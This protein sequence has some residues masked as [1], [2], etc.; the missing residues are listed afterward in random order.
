MASFLETVY[1]S[2]RLVTTLYGVL[3]VLNSL[4][5]FSV[6]A[7]SIWLWL[8]QAVTIGAVAVVIGLVLRLWGMSQ[9]IMWEVSGLFENIGTVQDGITSI[10]MPRLVEDKPARQGHR[11]PAGRDRVRAHRLPL[12]QGQ[13]RHRQPVA[14]REAGREG[15]AGRPLRRRQVDAGQPAAALLRPRKRPHPDRRPGHLGGHAGFAARQYR[16]GHAGHLA[17]APLGARQ[18]PLRPAGRQR[19][20]GGRG[21]AARRGARLHRR[22][23]PIRKAARASTRMSASAASS[24]RAASAS[25]SRSP[26]SC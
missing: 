11:R 2:M 26:A 18:H 16:H 4:L 3:Y 17:A 22:A 14:D 19:G 6:T 23:S 8:G 24:C 20:D 25:A 10:S 1:R 15:R 12:R 21:G 13:G 9:W 7:M 5:L